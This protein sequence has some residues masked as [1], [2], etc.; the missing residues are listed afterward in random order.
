M[1]S[2]TNRKA[3]I[4]KTKIMAS[5]VAI[6]L[7]LSISAS[8][9]LLPSTTAHTPIWKIPTYAFIVAEPNPVGVGQTINVYMWLD[10]LYGSAG[11]AS[12]TLGTNGSTSS[13]ALLSNN[14]RFHGYVLTITSPNGTSTT[15]TF[16][17]I[18]SSDSAQGTTFTP[19]MIG[20]YTLNFTYLGQVYGANGNGYSG[21]QLIND[22]YLPS[23]ASTNLTV[24]QESIPTGE[25]SAPIPTEYWTRPIYGA[26]IDWYSI[27]S[28]WLG[29]GS[30]VEST[31]GFNTLTGF[32]AQA[33]I[34]RYPGDAVGSQTS[35]IMWT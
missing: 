23:T 4:S 9:V 27:S 20:T 15:Q 28:N 1:L 11:G 8:L 12:A 33:Y 3:R 10:A 31:L 5:I 14:Y 25:I 6:I 35:H 18:S 19:T 2:L 34:Q 26:N 24:Q 21:S 7:M 16:D 29:T 17:V 30:G 13:G 22:T 32:T